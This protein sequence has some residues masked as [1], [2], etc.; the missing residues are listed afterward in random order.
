[1]SSLLQMVSCLSLFS[2]TKVHSRSPLQ[3]EPRGDTMTLLLWPQDGH[4]RA[5][6]VGT[7]SS[8]SYL[9]IPLSQ[10]K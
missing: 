5:W 4:H 3:G 9:S 1:M 2:F 7:L 10:A 8:P 6:G